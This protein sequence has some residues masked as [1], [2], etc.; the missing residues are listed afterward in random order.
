MARVWIRNEDCYHPWGLHARRDRCE[1]YM[2]KA[3]DGAWYAKCAA[4]VTDGGKARWRA[5]SRS[6]VFSYEVLHDMAVRHC[7]RHHG[8]QPPNPAR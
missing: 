5:G 8:K 6:G 1:T 3:E 2:E 4:C 7:V